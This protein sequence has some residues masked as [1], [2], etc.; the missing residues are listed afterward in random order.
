[1]KTA[2]E[3]RAHAEECRK[4]ARTLGGAHRDD[5]L[6]MADTWDRLADQRQP[7]QAR[8]PE[9]VVPDKSK[10]PVPITINI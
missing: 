9:Y 8:Q 1:M 7:G 5:V 2:S 4:L 6:K 10:E 3:Y